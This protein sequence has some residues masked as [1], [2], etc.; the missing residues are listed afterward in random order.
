MATHARAQILAAAAALLANL[1]TT[2][3]RCHISRANPKAAE[4][5]PFLLLYSRSQATQ[6]LTMGGA[7][8][9]LRHELVFAVEG[10]A[11]EA[12]DSDATL[13][14]IALEVEA[15][16]HAD[17]TLGGRCKDLHLTSTQLA[18]RAEGEARIGRIRLEFN[19]H[20]QTVATA[21]GTAV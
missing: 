10:V 1:P 6:P 17:P 8:R 5:G 4:Q 15:A 21:P 3:S 19:V 16:L 2:G 18:A 20:Y 14:D 7:G 12:G 9:K 13:D 11:P